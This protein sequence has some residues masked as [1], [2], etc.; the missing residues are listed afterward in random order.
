MLRSLLIWTMCRDNRIYDTG[1]LHVQS[2]SDVSQQSAT[3]TVS[4]THTGC[5][6]MSS[7]RFHTT[8]L[9]E[10]PWVTCHRNVPKAGGKEKIHSQ[11]R[12]L[13]M[14]LFMTSFWQHRPDSRLVLARLFG[15]AEGRMIHISS[16]SARRCL[17]GVKH[18][19]RTNQ[20]CKIKTV[21]P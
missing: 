6:S 1:N 3:I 19:R 7:S 10:I 5:P 9:T 16:V 13:K 8:R 20:Q 2:F 17:A 18:R 11:L 14:C 21:S 4:P 15:S 12:S